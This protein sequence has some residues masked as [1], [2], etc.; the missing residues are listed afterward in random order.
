MADGMPDEQPA[1]GQFLQAAP[2]F[3]GVAHKRLGEIVPAISVEHGTIH[4]VVKFVQ[5]LYGRTG[6]ALLVETVVGLG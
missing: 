6:F 2:R 3:A 1:G 4:P 5:M